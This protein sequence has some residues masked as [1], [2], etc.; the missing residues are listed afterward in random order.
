MNQTTKISIGIIIIILL[1]VGVVYG[2]R[3]MPKA[4]VF[5]SVTVQK[6]DVVQAVAA[7]GQV[8]A[9]DTYNLSFGTSGIVRT[10]NVAKGDHVQAGQILA[11]IDASDIAMQRA[12]AHAALLGDQATAQ[13]NLDKV[14]QA[15]KETASVN[16]ANVLAATQKVKDTKAY[17]D[18]AEGI[19]TDVSN[20][21]DI[22]T[23][24][25]TYITA[26]QTLATARS[27]YAEAQAALK[28]AQA[29]AAQSNASASHDVAIAQQAAM[30]KQNIIDAAGD[31]SVN[32][33]QLGYQNALLAKTVLRAPA[34]GILSSVDIHVGQYATPAIASATL[35][36]PALEIHAA[37]SDA[38]IAH[39]HSGQIAHVV[40][41]AL[42]SQ[43]FDAIVTSIDPAAKVDNGVSSYGIT[44][45]IQNHDNAIIPGMNADVTIPVIEKKNVVAIPDDALFTDKDTFFV[46]I[47]EAGGESHK[48]TVEI[49]VRGT[50]GYDEIV[51]GLT[52]GQTIL[53]F[54]TK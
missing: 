29:Q 14:T 5:Q 46:Q 17:L 34:A 54:S 31:I 2:V 3:V 12:S 6:H 7:S 53:S 16:T 18:T 44:L 52:P 10:V 13:A 23:T 40:F 21:G 20:D 28:T 38:D 51:S 35:L 39:I 48:Q 25:I 19:F 33:A 36:S 4:P 42:G 1:G 47:P 8:Q 50:N 43:E 37:V 24:S 30:L 9:K 41:D 49:G 11:T 27:N 15:Q 45:A 26:A 32:Q 22:D